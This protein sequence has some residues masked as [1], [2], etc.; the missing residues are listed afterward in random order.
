MTTL[1]AGASAP[2]TDTGK[3]IEVYK[4]QADG[5]WKVIRDIWNSSRPALVVPAGALKPDASTE[6]KQLAWLVGQWR[7]EGDA[8]ASPV[9]PAGKYALMMNCQWF[10]GGTQVVC[11]TEGTSP[12][13]AFQ[14]MAIYGY[15]GAIKAYTLF[16]INS[17][18]F[19][20][21]AKGSFQDGKGIYML[22]ARAEG[23]PMKLRFTLFDMSTSAWKWKDE[24]SLAGGPW[25]LADEGKATKIQ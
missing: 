17:A 8:K 16:D 23:K 25:T 24:V 19:S 6:L 9:G 12:T 3:G 7:L 2:V 11:G 5:T 22:D 20:A 15:D 14:E 21:S 1:P 10:P 4:K 18:G 13:G